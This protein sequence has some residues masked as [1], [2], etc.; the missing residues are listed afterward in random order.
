[1]SAAFDDSGNFFLFVYQIKR[2][3]SDML[4]YLLLNIVITRSIACH[5]VTVI[6]VRLVQV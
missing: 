3:E 5:S 6:F 2:S 4:L 1:M